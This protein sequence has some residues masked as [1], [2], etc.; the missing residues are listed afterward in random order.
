MTRM[1]TSK[2][3]RYQNSGGS[4]FY[5][6]PSYNLLKIVQKFIYNATFLNNIK[7]LFNDVGDYLI[8]CKVYPF[9]VKNFLTAS[10]NY[11]NTDYVIEYMKFANNIEIKDGNNHING[12][13]FKNRLIATVRDVAVY[14][15]NETFNSFLDYEPYTKYQIYLPYSSEG[16]ID[17]D[18]NMYMNKT[19]RIDLSV[20]FATGECMYDFRCCDTDSISDEGF[21]AETHNGVCGIDVAF[22]QSNKNEIARNLL[23]TGINTTSK[24]LGVG[25]NASYKTGLRNTSKNLGQFSAIQ[26]AQVAL[27]STVDIVNDLH[28]KFNKSMESSGFLDFIKPQT[29]YLIKS[30][31]NVVYPNNYN[32]EYGR[33]CGKSLTL[34]S[35][36]GFTKVGA[37]KLERFNN[38]TDGELNELEILL[39]EGVIM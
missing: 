23:L 13:R 11:Q 25:A 1:V 19:L 36:V 8:S 30:T 31:P 5:I 21:V 10:V 15:F 22:S 16:F 3:L 26:T 14:T 4:K 12:T 20:N 6:I 9:S 7:L 24:L 18:V 38:I 37:C 33:P 29:I 39:K 27:G 28:T 35:C 17:I 34:G 2:I 32:H